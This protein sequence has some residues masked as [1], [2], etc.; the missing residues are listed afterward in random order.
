MLQQ[1]STLKLELSYQ[2]LSSIFRVELPKSTL[3]IESVA[4]DTRK[5][6]NGSNTLFF[7][8]KGEFRD[9]HEYINEAYRKGVRTFVVSKSTTEELKGATF[10]HVEDPLKALQTLAKNHRDQFSYPIVAAQY[11]SLYKKV[12]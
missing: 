8:L 2:D 3:T 5:I 4:F 6:I 12:L 9:G 7:A 1:N 11:I 10:V